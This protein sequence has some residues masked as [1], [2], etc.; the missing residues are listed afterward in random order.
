MI[1]CMACTGHCSGW[2]GRKGDCRCEVVH[3]RAGEA[4]ADAVS[5]PAL[6][7][8]WRVRV[9]ARSQRP[10]WPRPKRTV[11]SAG[12]RSNKREDLNVSTDS[13]LIQGLIDSAPT[14][15]GVYAKT[16]DLEPR[17][18]DVDE[19]VIITTP[20]CIRGN[21]TVIKS[22]NPGTAAFLVEQPASYARFEGLYLLGPGNEGIFPE[23]GDR[24][25]HQSWTDHYRVLPFF[26]MAG[27]SVPPLP[28]GGRGDRRHR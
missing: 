7:R 22:T 17:Q 27:S 3:R 25:R 19:P 2:R 13:K 24:F 15:I 5:R 8:Q 9:E 20:I 28:I 16:I 26:A 14:A 4:Q 1:G 21:N 12:N 23:N 11:Q 6:V 18:Y 10:S